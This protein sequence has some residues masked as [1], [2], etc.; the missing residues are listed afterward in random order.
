ML[1]IAK[2]VNFNKDL[3][4][5][6]YKE[7]TNHANRV[8]YDFFYVYHE[9]YTDAD[10][11]DF[12]HKMIEVVSDLEI[13]VIVEF[14][15]T[16]FEDMKKLYYANVK[17]IVVG[18]GTNVAEDVLEEGKKR[19]GKDLLIEKKSFADNS[20]II[21]GASDIDSFDKKFENDF[22][23]LDESKE[24]INVS[25]AKDSLKNKGYDTKALIPAI[26]FS[27]LKKNDDGLVPCIVTDYKTDKVLMLAYMNEEAY[28]N[29][30]KTGLMTYY[31][32]SRK[33][34]WVKGETSGH[35]Q[36]IKYMKADCDK[37]TLIAGVSQIGVPCHT[38]ADTCFFN[39]VLESSAIVKDPS[40]ILDDLY[41][42]IEDRKSNPKEGS[43]TNYLFDK[44]LDKILKKVG[45]EACEILI[46]S[47]N[48]EPKEIKY[49]IADF[50]YHLSVLMVEKGVTWEEVAVE[51]ANR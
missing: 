10:K 20:L 23:I 41:K 2:S 1:Y 43:Y 49:E 48:E 11:E 21:K 18:E 34:Q 12:F 46:A 40:K 14:P 45:E 6:D 13:P 51:L 47:K 42:V 30:F 7:L 50:L 22:Y 39:D 5:K 27:E 33:E 26:A 8:G 31:S 15:I 36:Y 16:H 9:A 29:T 28:N 38:G 3:K 35:Y 17:Y 32:R 19:F 4:D 37:D 25:L 44:G 24:G